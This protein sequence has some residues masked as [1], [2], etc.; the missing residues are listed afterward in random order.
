MQGSRARV[1]DLHAG[2][3]ASPFGVRIGLVRHLE[4]EIAAAVEN[5]PALVQF[6]GQDHVGAV[7][8]HEVGA[9]L[10]GRV[11]VFAL[12]LQD[13][14]AIAPVQ[15]GD[16]HV[17][18][19]AQRRHVGA[20]LRQR[21]GAGPGQDFGRNARARARRLCLQARAVGGMGLD[22]GD[23][24]LVGAGFVVVRPVHRGALQEAVA[25]AIAH[26]DQWRARGGGIRAGADAGQGRGPEGGQRRQHGF[27]AD[28]DVVGVAHR[29]E[30]RVAQG[31]GVPG[32]GIEAPALLRMLGQVV[33]AAFQVGEDQVR[34]QQGLAD[35]IEQARGV[36]D[37]LEIDVAQQIKR[38]IHGGV[39]IRSSTL[40]K[41]EACRKSTTR[42][43]SRSCGMRRCSGC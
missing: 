13:F 27:V 25:H 28:I 9:G 11:R 31:L 41:A 26:F 40:P 15:R 34:R 1:A 36:V 35:L 23:A 39:P 16:H 43:L 37:A 29:L 38:V 24:G 8:Q 18:L 4:R 2:D 17:R 32:R 6:D 20:E 10:D 14:A 12:V 7:S 30:A 19:G 21:F 5:R 22:D 33:Q 42:S 3:H